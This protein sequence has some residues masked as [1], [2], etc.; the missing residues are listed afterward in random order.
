MDFEWS[1]KEEEMIANIEKELMPELLN[2]ER[3][4]QSEDIGIIKQEILGC[5]RRLKLA[6]YPDWFLERENICPFGLLLRETLASLN[7]HVYFAVELGNI[8]SIKLLDLFPDNSIENI[9]FALKDLTAIGALDIVEDR[10]EKSFR[11]TANIG[12]ADFVLT[13]ELKE[14]P[15]LLVF[16][17]KEKDVFL[18]Y[19]QLEKPFGPIFWNVQ[20]KLQAGRVNQIETSL[21]DINKFL[22][23]TKDEILMGS[24]LGIMKKAFETAK[25]FSK[26][27]K[28][29]NKPLIAS[30]E[31]G[32]KLAEMLTLVDASRY[33]ALRALWMEEEDE[34]EAEILRF[35][36]KAFC[37][38]SAE[39][40]CSDAIQVLG[41]VSF[42]GSSPMKD[43][44]LFSKFLGVSGTPTE[45]AR[46]KIG[47]LL[48]K[49]A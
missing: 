5:F 11:L 46:I 24:A 27:E 21:P 45:K 14:H 31:I 19:V 2:L 3:I 8:F 30:Q 37:V 6:H 9:Y 7:L 13:L 35:C 29:G 4:M 1:V 16:G 36:A 41:L 10:T 26:K 32:F 48:L 20:G 18:S 23:K 49:R 25:E 44:Y 17:D 42:N 47:D 12:Y 15:R 38:E 28:S 43:F 39:K 34:K 33:L 40:I 22:V